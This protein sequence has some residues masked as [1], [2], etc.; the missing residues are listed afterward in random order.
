MRIV[1]SD[2]DLVL[3]SIKCVLNVNSITKQDVDEIEQSLSELKLTERFISYWYLAQAYF[4]IEEKEKAQNCH[5]LAKSM[6]TETAN[7][8]SNLE[9]RDN[10]LNNIYF[11]KRLQED[12]KEQSKAVEDTSKVNIFTFCPSCGFDNS[13]KFAF[14]PKCG[15]DLKSP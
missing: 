10:F 5:D 6:L 14:C 4:G 12:I 2:F 8:N 1:V 7:N 9:D 13:N 3:K 11:H 15:Q